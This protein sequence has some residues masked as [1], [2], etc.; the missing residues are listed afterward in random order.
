MTLTYPAFT[1]IFSTDNPAA[2]QTQI[3]NE[4]YEDD[5]GNERELSGVTC[6]GCWNDMYECTCLPEREKYYAVVAGCGTNPNWYE[7]NLLVPE[8]EVEY[9]KNAFTN[10]HDRDCNCG[11]TLKILVEEV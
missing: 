8:S 6:G 9:T 3:E 10:L 2:D 1:G 7:Y 4:Q 5:W 11:G